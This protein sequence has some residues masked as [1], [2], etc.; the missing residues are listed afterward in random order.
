MARAPRK[1]QIGRLAA[2]TLDEESLGTAN[3]DVEH[4]R[5]V[6]IYDLLEDNKFQPVGHD[7]GPYELL[8]GIGN[9]ESGWRKEDGSSVACSWSMD[10][11]HVLSTVGGLCTKVLKIAARTRRSQARLY[12]RY[13]MDLQSWHC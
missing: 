12:C 4:E 9:F 5:R 7:G 11:A 6:A 3:D 1:D 2:I 10:E 8:D 13:P